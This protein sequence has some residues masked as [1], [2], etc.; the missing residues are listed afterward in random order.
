MVLTAMFFSAEIV[1][2]VASKCDQAG[3]SAWMVVACSAGI[4]VLS[5]CEAKWF[6]YSIGGAMFLLQR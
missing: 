4:H 5:N 6:F 1:Q 3:L 2:Q